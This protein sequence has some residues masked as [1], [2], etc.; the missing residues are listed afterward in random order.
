M[1]DRTIEEHIFTLK[2]QIESQE[3]IM[4]SALKQ[5]NSYIN[6]GHCDWMISI[7]NACDSIRNAAF[8]HSN[9]RLRLE[10]EE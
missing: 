10:Y 9:L 5:L 4:K 6:D 3:T 1:I 8:Y 2:K 7:I